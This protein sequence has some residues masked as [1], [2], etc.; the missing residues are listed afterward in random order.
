VLFQRR[1][2]SPELPAQNVV[3]DLRNPLRHIHT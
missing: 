1:H 3:N 2:P